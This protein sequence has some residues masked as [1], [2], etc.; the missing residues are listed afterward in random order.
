MFSCKCKILLALSCFLAL[1]PT[2]ALFTGCQQEKRITKQSFQTLRELADETPEPKEPS[3]LEKRAKEG[4]WSILLAEF[5]ETDAKRR[6]QML[7]LRLQQET[8]LEET[9]VYSTRDTASVYFGVFDNTNTPDA[10]TAL[11]RV[12]DTTLDNVA[13]F[14]FADFVPIGGT[15]GSANHPMNLKQY[16]GMYTLQV[17]VFD[18]KYPDGRFAGAEQY[19]RQLREDGQDAYFYHGPHRSMVT[20]GLWGRE[21]AFETKENPRLPGTFVDVYA[22]HVRELQKE[23]PHNLLNGYTLMQGVAG[24]EEKVEQPSRLVRIP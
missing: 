7:S 13:Y 11:R 14:E 18:E 19:A 21:Q 23:Y 1:I 6:A 22:S 24:E 5:R 12:H 20:I 15:A 2:L 8:P 10:Q 3:E 4:G 17:A 9:W 16:T